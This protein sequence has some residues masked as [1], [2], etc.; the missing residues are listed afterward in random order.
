MSMRSITRSFAKPS[1]SHVDPAIELVSVADIPA[2][3]G[4]A[5]RGPSRSACCGRSTP[6]GESTC[7]LHLAEEACSSKSTAGSTRG[8]AGPVHRRLRRPHLLDFEPDGQ[9]SVSP[10]LVSNETLHDLEEHLLMFFTGFSRGQTGPGDQKARSEDDDTEMLEN[11]HFVKG[12]GQATSRPRAGRHV[13]LRRADARALAAQRSA[14]PS[15]SNGDIDR[16]YDRP[17]TR[18]DRGEAGRGGGGGFLLFYA[19]DQDPRARH[20]RR[21]AEG[22]PLPVRSRRIDCAHTRPTCNA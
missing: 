12:I 5:R 13:G 9:V 2:G 14:R 19:R 11:L 10:I 7:P 1:C 8:Q 22:G 18:R 3:T 17:W 16:W 4:L 21:R 15:M 20:D 6:T